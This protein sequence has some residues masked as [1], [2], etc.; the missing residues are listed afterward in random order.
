MKNDYLI[1]RD[2]EKDF[3]KRYNSHYKRDIYNQIL[4]HNQAVWLFG[5]RWVW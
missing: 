5:E 3:I 2:L 4:W 1:L